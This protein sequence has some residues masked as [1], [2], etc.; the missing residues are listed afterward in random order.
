MSNF[1]PIWITDFFDLNYLLCVGLT[2]NHKADHFITRHETIWC[3][4]RNQVKQD[5]GGGEG[6]RGEGGSYAN[7]FVQPVERERTTRKM[8]HYLS[9]F[10]ASPV[11]D[12][13]E[14]NGWK[15]RGWLGYS[16]L[17]QSSEGFT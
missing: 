15:G 16:V 7:Y 1:F 11:E 5:G 8:L 9:I 12:G 14:S 3:V 6:G 17:S 10:Y 13:V 4:A 2:L